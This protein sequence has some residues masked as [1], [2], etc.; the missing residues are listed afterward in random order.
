MIVATLAHMMD[1]DAVDTFKMHTVMPTGW[2]VAGSPLPD[3]N[4]ASAREGRCV[5]CD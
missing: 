1:Q 3:D 5:A 4:V 2:L